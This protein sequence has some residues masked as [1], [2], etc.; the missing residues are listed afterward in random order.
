M[1]PK[2][3]ILCCGE[4][5]IDMI[6]IR[7][8][9]HG[10][11]YLPCSGGAVFNTAIGLGRL[12]CDTAFLSGLSDDLFGNQLVKSLEESGVSSDLS[13]RCHRP[14]TLA[15]V[16]L[17]N[18]QARYAFYDE[19]TAGRMFGPDDVP[20]IPSD[21][22]VLFFGGISLCVEPCACTYEMLAQRE[23]STRVVMLDPNIRPQFVKNE[24]E[25]RQRIETMLELSDIVKVSDEDL[26]WLCGAQNGIGDGLEEQANFLLEKGPSIIWVT[27]GSKGA[28]A[29]TRAGLSLQVTAPKTCVVDTVGAGD[30]FNAAILAKLAELDWLEKRKLRSIGESALREVSSFATQ[31]AAITVSRQGANPPWRDELSV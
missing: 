29:F 13:P 31:V 5:L 6:P 9:Q 30:S 22:D 18:G 1:K 11:A 21:I 7:N 12:G 10:L 14:T 25:Y 28:A 26:A 8:D 4:A 16:E 19:N 15:F 3:K 24:G 23:A 2:A 27:L 17:S 20:A